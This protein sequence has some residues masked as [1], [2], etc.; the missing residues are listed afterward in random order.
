MCRLTSVPSN[1]RDE[2]HESE[3]TQIITG[4]DSRVT[5]ANIN[6]TWHPFKEILYEKLA[7]NA[8]KMRNAEVRAKFTKLRGNMR[9]VI[10]KRLA[11]MVDPSK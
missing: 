10:F 4:K 7:I 9:K 2:F 5:A 3:A 8:L 11:A 1:I 6:T